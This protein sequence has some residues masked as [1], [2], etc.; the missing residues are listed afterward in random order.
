MQTWRLDLFINTITMHNFDL[1]YVLNSLIRNSSIS[2]NTH[3]PIESQRVY[4]MNIYIYPLYI[5]HM[6]N[7]TKVFYN[8][9]L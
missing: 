8:R 6:Y 1:D 5:Y 9:F 4:T 7:N 2:Y 3:N